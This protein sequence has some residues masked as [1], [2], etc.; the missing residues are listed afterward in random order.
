MNTTFIK[1]LQASFIIGAIVFTVAQ[2]E[3]IPMV[4]AGEPSDE[5]ILVQSNNAFAI[6]LYNEL[7]AAEGNIFF[8]PHSISTA[9]S[10][11]LAGARGNTEAEMLKTL[12]FKLRQKN[13]HPA[14]G[15]ILSRLTKIQQTGDVKLSVANSLWPQKGYK[16]L[17]EY[18]SLIKK[19]YGVS[20][21]AVDYVKARE[22]AREM[23]NSWVED[24]TQNKV[25]D[26]IKPGIL[27]SL[28]RLVLVNA[29]YFKGN[30]EFQF[31]TDQTKIGPF[32]LSPQKSVQAPLMTQK[33]EFRYAE[34]KSLQMLELP[35]TGNR[36]SM[37]VLLPRNTDGLELLESSLT[38]ENLNLWNRSLRKRKVVVS[39]PK[40]KMTSMFRLD[41]ALKSMGMVDAFS[42]K[43]NFSGMDGRTNWLY[44]GAVLHKAFV[45]VNEEGTEAAAA[46]AVVMKARAIPS[47]P[48][49]FRA[50]HPF[51][52]LIQEN[53]TGSILFMGR[54]S[55]PTK[56]GE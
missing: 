35:Y 9:L 38:A 56:T 42:M 50:D 53:T 22:A 4:I 51:I 41:E 2:M 49:I 17:D 46:T 27:D 13:L 7:R 52:F 19:H 43:A 30:W 34:F 32:Y 11:T 55:D 48:K 29:I 24:K 28:T 21:T 25:K 12:C 40:F 14:F 16:L 18:M 54:V 10:M 36:L 20:I 8:S 15:D 1:R 3:K 37:I 6:A 45:D 5:Q 23:I 44:I 31:E 39:L 47:A 33:Q 26:L